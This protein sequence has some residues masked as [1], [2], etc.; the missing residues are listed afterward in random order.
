MGKIDAAA[1]HAHEDDFHL[2]LTAHRLF[3]DS[4]RWHLTLDRLFV[5]YVRWHLSFDRL[6][7]GVMSFAIAFGIAVIGVDGDVHN[8]QN[9]LIDGVV[10]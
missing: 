5:G 1:T 2:S 7:R 3:M 4:V 9:P 10:E 6:L 8:V